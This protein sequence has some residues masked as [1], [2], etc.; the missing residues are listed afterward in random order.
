M[1]PRQID[2]ILASASPRR[3]ELLRK[4]VKTFRII[5]SRVD[6]SRIGE[7]D[8]V[9]FAETAAALKAEDVGGRYP[10][11]I[12]LA[13]DTIVCLGDRIFGKPRDR[14]DA[15][16]TLEALSGRRHRVITAVVLY[17][18]NAGRRETSLETSFVRFRTL[19]PEAIDRYLA[20]GGFVDKAGSYA[21][22]E[23]G[24]AFVES[25]EGDYDNVVGLPVGKVR[26][27]LRKFL[28]GAANGA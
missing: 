21:I 20:A 28:D 23:V 7:T 15:A 6:E 9:L 16:A 26:E 3:E 12:V 5:P 19:S 14:E 24:D 22:Q 4:V 27:L 10:D 11:A 2:V 17:Q 1:S 18:K 13:A 8:P 25:L